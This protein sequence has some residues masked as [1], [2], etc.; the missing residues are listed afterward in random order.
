MGGLR[1]DVPRHRRDP[2]HALGEALLLQQHERPRLR[3]V[4]Q[5][6]PPAEFHAVPLP[7]RVPGL[8]QEGGD[9]LARDGHDADR[10]RVR[11]AEHGAEAA[12]LPGG[13]EGRRRGPDGE[14]GRDLPPDGGLH[15]RELRG[16]RRRAPGEVGP[17]LGLVAQGT[18][19]VDPAR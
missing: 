2:S 18:L 15:G 14:G 1:D 6:G 7:P 19:L 16:R 17:E 8:R 12:D 4:G 3:R 13:G 10:V 5:V 11:L 9:L